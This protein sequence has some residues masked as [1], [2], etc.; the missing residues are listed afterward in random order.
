MNRPLSPKHLCMGLNRDAMCTLLVCNYFPH[1][2]HHSKMM[3]REES[4][5]S[6]N[7]VSGIVNAG[8]DRRCGYCKEVEW[9]MAQKVPKDPIFCLGR[10]QKM[11]IRTRTKEHRSTMTGPPA[12]SNL[13]D[14]PTGRL[15]VESYTPYTLPYSTQA[16]ASCLEILWGRRESSGA[17]V[18][19]RVFSNLMLSQLP[20]PAFAPQNASHLQIRN[21]ASCVSRR[22]KR[23]GN[24]VCSQRTPPTFL[25]ELRDSDGMTN[26]EGETGKRKVED[27]HDCDRYLIHCYHY[28]YQ[29]RVMNSGVNRS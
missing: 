26:G 5:E 15:K 24:T 7:S 28:R 17:S 29:V 23:K 18:R 27:H 3:A 13:R 25:I 8:P 22:V 16:C 6:T 21:W 2:E 14:R 20:I 4:A 11:L 9:L 19:R 12:H 1:S 10:K